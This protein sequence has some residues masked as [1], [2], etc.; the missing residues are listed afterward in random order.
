[1]RASASVGWR[2]AVLALL[3]SAA[4]DRP[5]AAADEQYLVE[6][7]A[8]QEAL[9]AGDAALAMAHAHLAWLEAEEALGDDRLT[10]ILAY[11][12]ALLLLVHDPAGA[13]AALERAVE[14][15]EAGIGDLDPRRLEVHAAYAGFSADEFRWGRAKRLQKALA[16]REAEAENADGFVEHVQMWLALAVGA[17]TAERYSL[18]EESAARA[19]SLILANAAEPSRVLAQAL[20]LEGIAKLVPLPR[21]V[22]D[23]QDAHNLFGRARRQFEPQPGIHD[24]DPLLAQVV[25]WNGTAGAA[26]KALGKDDYPDHAD[27]DDG[28]PDDDTT[29]SVPD[30]FIE[31]AYSSEACDGLEWEEREAPRYPSRAL[32]RGYIGAVIIGF[33][34]S[35]DWTVKDATILAEVPRQAFSEAALES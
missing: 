8:Y 12:Y 10:S 18:A 16:A 5:A 19:E 28:E 17:V 23:V 21:S 31:S 26:L 7:R 34:L 25:A 35:E 4:P 33:N 20:L 13:V 24:F 27:A 22:D 29:D 15:Q 14:L 11:N 32:R 30:L 1:M 9:E 2:T 6:Y 3:F